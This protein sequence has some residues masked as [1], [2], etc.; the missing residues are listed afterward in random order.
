M[1]FEELRVVVVV[2]TTA[3][4]PIIILFNLYLKGQLSSSTLK[5]YFTTFICCALGW[6]LWFTYG[7]YAGDPVDIR[8]SDILNQF[9]PKHI[10]WLMNSLADAGT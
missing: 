6:E 2:Y 4:L 10:N 8:R 1:T 3:I 9:L 7:I 5:I